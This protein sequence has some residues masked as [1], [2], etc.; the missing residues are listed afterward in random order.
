MENIRVKVYITTCTETAII[1]KYARQGDAGMDVYADE[2][3]LI[4]PG[5]TV[6]VSTG[7][8]VALPEGYELQVRPRS[9][10]SLNTP[11]RVANSPGTI[12]SGYRDEIK[13]IITNTGAER[14]E[15]SMQ[16][17]QSGQ[18]EQS[19]QS[20]QSGQSERSIQNGQNKQSGHLSDNPGFGEH[21]KDREN[22]HPKSDYLTLKSKG[23][24]KGTYLI[25]KG[26]RIAQIVLK[27]TPVIEWEKV[28]SLKGIGTDRKGGFGSTGV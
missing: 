17:S 1:P 3:V 22:I 19:A 14:S 12:D 20:I 2:E 23:N 27:R 25:Q 18:S 16:S 5:E 8:K 7:I 24:I 21:N 15:R 6:A 9:G 4:K 13:I 26:D 10:I 11:L 28:E